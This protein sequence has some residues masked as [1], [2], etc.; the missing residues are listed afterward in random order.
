MLGLSERVAN[1]CA[2]AASKS[3]SPARASV[4]LWIRMTIADGGTL[5]RSPGA[6]RAR[7]ASRSLSEKPPERSAPGSCGAN[8]TAASEQKHGPHGDHRPAMTRAEEAETV[9]EAHVR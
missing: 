5:S 9:E 8:G 1:A 6:C 7:D 2:A 4:W 3:G